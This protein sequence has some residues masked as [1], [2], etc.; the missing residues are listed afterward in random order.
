MNFLLRNP[1]LVIFA[2]IFIVVGGYIFFLKSSNADLT[3]ENKDLSQQNTVL[4]AKVDNFNAEIDSYN[5]RIEDFR[6]E[7]EVVRQEKDKL[8]KVLDK[9]SLQDIADRKPTLLEKR[10]NAATKKLF[11]ELEEM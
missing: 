8:I 6:S 4:E 9:H 10:I 2:I 1:K 3:L 11:D 7:Q 5:K